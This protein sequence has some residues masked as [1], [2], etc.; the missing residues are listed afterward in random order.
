MRGTM[1]RA[2]T[3]VGALFLLG[4]SLIVPQIFGT[5]VPASAATVTPTPTP[6]FVPPACGTG[7]PAYNYA[8]SG[9]AADPQV[10]YSAGTYYA[11]TTGNA[12]GN[13]IAALVS[14]SPNS[15]YGPYTHQCYGSTALPSPSPW[16][17][18]N[19]Q[20][21]PGVFQYGGHWVMFY[22]AARSG[23]G[24]D[25][26]YDCLTVA[27]AASISS[28]DAQF[29]D[30]SNSPIECQSTGSIDPEPYVDPNTNIAYL[31]WKQNDGGSSAP[32]YIWAQQL[33]SSGTGFA[34]S[35]APSLLL[36]NNTVSYPWETTVVDPSM[37]AAGGGFFLAFSA[38]AYTSTS[39]SEGITTC[40]GPLGPCGPQSQVLTTY[41]AVLGPGGGSLFSDAAGNWW[42]DYAAWQGGP[43]GCTS[44]ACGAARRLFVAPINLPSGNGEVPCNAPASAYGYYMVASDGGIFNY[45]DLPFCGSEGG[46]FLNKPVV[47]MAATRDGGGYWLVASDGGIFN[48]GDAPFHGSAGSIALNKPIVG[49]AATPDGGGYWLVASDGGIFN[50]GDAGFYGSAGSIHLNKPI[51]GMAPTASGKGYWLVASDGGIFSYGDA[52]FHGSAGSLS[53]NK[54]VVGMAAT[55]DGGGYWLVATDGGIFNYGDAPFNGS[56]GSIPLAEPV[57]G[58]STP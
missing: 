16:E 57:V 13:N 24:S 8:G 32:A 51:V 49:M 21:S 56:A 40:N 7:A 45:G 3:G 14:S 46:R 10:V 2:G 29:S 11:F 55:H 53:L 25:S 18:P 48:Y 26:G 50:Y 1:G 15:G 12:L 34:P 39:Y 43:P 58:M 9:D 37:E 47:G 41:G 31:V 52:T 54:P 20:T 33:N 30:V 22:D 5:A 27:T 19:T 42:L 23:H 38:G 17:Q 6:A 28:S 35:S 36:T 4:A 44:Y